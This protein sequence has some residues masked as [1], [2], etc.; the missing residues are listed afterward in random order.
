MR[1]GSPDKSGR[2]SPR[3]LP[4]NDI[5]AFSPKIPGKKFNTVQLAEKKL[6]SAFN[7]LSMR[8]RS[9]RRMEPAALAPGGPEDE[10]LGAELFK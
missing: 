10:F 4:S 9:A 1:E 8:W 3:I 6:Y 7:N 5:A 2:I